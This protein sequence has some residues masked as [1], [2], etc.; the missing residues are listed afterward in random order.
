M[1]E[2]HHVQAVPHNSLSPI[3]LAACLQVSGAIP[4]FAIQEFTTG[5]EAD[6]F[7]SK[8]EHLG[9]DIVDKVPLP[10]D[11]FVDIPPGPRLG[12]NLREDAQ[13]NRAPLA[14][15]IKMRPHRYG[16]IVGQ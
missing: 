13:S 15:S 9:S 6:V 7:E 16:F 11:G 10:K 3:G 5:F 8:S 2:V 1:A 14:Q 4:N 12:M